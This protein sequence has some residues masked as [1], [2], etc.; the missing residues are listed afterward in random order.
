[1]IHIISAANRHLYRDQVE[2]MHQLRRV[3]FVEECGWKDMNIVDGGEYDQFDD[4]RTV[5]FLAFG[6][7][8]QPVEEWRVR[9]DSNS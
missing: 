3:H 4:D 5:Y 9:R 1:M 7:G 2:Q 6:P 8:A